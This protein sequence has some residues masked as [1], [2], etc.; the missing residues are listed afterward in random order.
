MDDLVN[1]QHIDNEKLVDDLG[2]DEIDDILEENDNYEDAPNAFTGQPSES[3]PSNIYD[4]QIITKTIR[5]YNPLKHERVKRRE[6]KHTNN[7]RA[8]SPSPSLGSKDG[9]SFKIDGPILCILI[10]PPLPRFLTFHYP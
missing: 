1:E 3:I 2:H 4:P 7:K 9:V 5:F 8:S 10:S 6:G